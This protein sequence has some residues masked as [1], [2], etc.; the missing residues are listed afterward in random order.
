MIGLHKDF[1]SVP[2]NTMVD[3]REVSKRVNITVSCDQLVEGDETFDIV[4]SLTNK[5]PQ[6]TTGRGRSIGRITDSTGQ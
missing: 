1:D 5:N 4:L 6:V 2:I 3:V